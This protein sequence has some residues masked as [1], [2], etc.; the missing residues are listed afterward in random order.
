MNKK[1]Y[2]VESEMVHA[3]HPV[4]DPFGS[5]VVPIYQTSTFRFNSVEDGRRFFAHEEGGGTHAYT[6]L[7]NPTTDRLEEA[8]ALLE[9][10]NI[11]EEVGALSFGSGMA[12][13]S[14]ALIAIAKGGSIVAQPDLYGCTG[15]FLREEAP[16]LGI[17]SHFADL[18]D[19]ESLERLLKENPEVKVI[20]GESMANP[21][22]KIL[23]VP[24]VAELAKKYNAVFMVD[25]TFATPF[26]QRPL[27]LGADMVMHST[28]KYLNGH[29]TLI[30]GALIA[31]KEL[32][33]EYSVPLYRKNLGGVTSPFESWLNLNGLKTFTLR[34]KQH[35][36]NGQAVAEFLEGHD[37]VN[38]VYYPGLESHDQH[39]LA[40]QLFEKGYGG[41][42]SFE[43]EGG[44]EAGVSLMD[45]VEFCTLA[46]SLG[47]VDTLIQ[48]PASMTHS[49][50]GPEGR[51]E[52]GISD[53]LVRL[54]VGI[55]NVDD[56]ISDLEQA[57]AK[58]K[59]EMTVA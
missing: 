21:T 39:N 57:L 25:N 14:T 6:R 41:V 19:L 32:L 26:H 59:S 30:G 17:K 28:T 13:I 16:E 24:A 31:R 48:H 15:Q 54:A 45:N 27:E 34:M 22:M 36:L 1:K 5:H 37:T 58:H 42:M 10:E 33:E 46:V 56:I 23:N 8:F 7:G 43:L 18:N 50:M 9:G 35:A 4:N 12:A 20:Y 11:S 53:G 29:G 40:D 55:E 52:A 38:K 2:S 51:K 44:Y 47:T 49:V 3:D